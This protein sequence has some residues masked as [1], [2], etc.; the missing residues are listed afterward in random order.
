MSSQQPTAVTYGLYIEQGATW[1]PDHIVM[2]D[3]QTQVPLDLT[4]CTARMHIRRTLPDVGTLIEL[5]TNNGRITLGGVA[6]T[7]ALYI[8]DEDT[9][10]LNF[11]SA[12]YDLELEY[13][14]GDV[15]RLLQGGVTLSKE[16]T[17]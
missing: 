11:K 7:I 12:V 17:R 1:R 8:S 10:L 3:K 15:V 4:G 2:R 9:A 14:N 13:P 16:V 5:T 6:G